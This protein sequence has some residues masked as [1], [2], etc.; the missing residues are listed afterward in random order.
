VCYGG[1]GEEESHWC[2]DPKGISILFVFILLI[3]LFTQLFFYTLISAFESPASKEVGRS[4][5]RALRK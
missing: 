5:S 4:G 2:T 3:Y 1:T